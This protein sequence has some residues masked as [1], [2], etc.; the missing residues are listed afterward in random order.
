MWKWFMVDSLSLNVLICVLVKSSYVLNSLSSAI[1]STSSSSTYFITYTKTGRWIIFLFILMEGRFMWEMRESWFAFISIVLRKWTYNFHCRVFLRNILDVNVN[2]VRHFDTFWL[3]W[4]LWGSPSNFILR[5]IIKS[6]ITQFVEY[7]YFQHIFLIF[8]THMILDMFIRSLL[9]L[10]NE[11][12]AL[13]VILATEMWI[14]IYWA[15]LIGL[16]NCCS[17]I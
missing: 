7:S 17:K 14:V 1:A 16:K 12:V 8:P 2:F 11:P 4:K 13:H 5:T 9:H 15:F 3:H 6:S 10:Y